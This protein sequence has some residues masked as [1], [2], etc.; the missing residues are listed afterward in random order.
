MAWRWIGAIV[1]IAL[2]LVNF[3]SGLLGIDQRGWTDTLVDLAK[4]PGLI[5]VGLSARKEMALVLIRITAAAM[6]C[7]LL[8]EAV[9]SKVGFIDVL[10]QILWL[11][12]AACLVVALSA[13]LPRKARSHAYGILIAFVWVTAGAVLINGLRDGHG[14]LVF[15]GLSLIAVSAFLTVIYQAWSRT[16]Y[17][18]QWL[19]DHMKIDRSDSPL[20]FEARLSRPL[21]R[22]RR[23]ALERSVTAAEE[24]EQTVSA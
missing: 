23:G 3:G 19:L 20:L 1:G 9:R 8:Y 5:L 6:A 10:P 13:W 7:L 16:G 14:G 18:P 21:D 15:G 12:F 4:F 2:C 17:P 22:P 11:S 24:K